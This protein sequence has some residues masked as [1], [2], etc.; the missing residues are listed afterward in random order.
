[1]PIGVAATVKLYRSAKILRK[2][3]HPIVDRPPGIQSF[4]GPTMSFLRRFFKGLIM[5]QSD[6]LLL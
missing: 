1:M 6:R 4:G 5:E 3:T 2:N